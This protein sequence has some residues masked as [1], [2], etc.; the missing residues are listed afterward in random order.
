LLGIH[1][2]LL[3]PELHLGRLVLA[4]TIRKGL[5]AMAD[6]DKSAGLFA[7]GCLILA[8]C[9]VGAIGVLAWQ[10]YIYLRTG[11][12]PGLSAIDLLRW[13]GIAWADMPTDWIGVHRLLE[14]TPLSLS[15]FLGGFAL[16]A[17]FS[18]LGASEGARKG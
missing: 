15:I 14:E 1:R 13:L 7:L 5:T 9:F 4:A 11:S 6:S 2:R 8:S 18:L 17:F 16:S 3:V 12:W 10:V